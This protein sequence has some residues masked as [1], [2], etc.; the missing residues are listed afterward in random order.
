MG[1]L[2]RFDL[3]GASGSTMGGYIFGEY[4]FEQALAWAFDDMATGRAVPISVTAEGGAI[5]LDAAAIQDAYAQAQQRPG[6]SASPGRGNR[7]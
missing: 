2:Y 6:D 7:G 5:E 4:T 1:A 3:V